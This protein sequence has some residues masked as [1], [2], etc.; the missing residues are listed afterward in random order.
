MVSSTHHRRSGAPGH[1]RRPPLTT[2][3]AALTTGS[4]VLTTAARLLTTGTHRAGAGTHHVR[5]PGGS[6]VA[7]SRGEQRGHR[8]WSGRA[9]PSYVFPGSRTGPIPVRLGVVDRA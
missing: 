5:W 3:T 6:A 4:L 2:A 1:A 7:W 9:R 8:P